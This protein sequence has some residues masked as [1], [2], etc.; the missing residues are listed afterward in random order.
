MQVPELALACANRAVENVMREINQP[1]A[2]APSPGHPP[3]HQVSASRRG[4]VF[5]M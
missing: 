2:Q 1:R 5:R 3:T 4:V